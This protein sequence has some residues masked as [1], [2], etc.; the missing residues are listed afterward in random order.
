METGKS[1]ASIGKTWF[2][3]TTFIVAITTIARYASNFDTNA[4]AVLVLHV[5]LYGGI[6]FLAGWAYGKLKRK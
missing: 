4:A 6:A 1:P 5:L 2:Y 3:W